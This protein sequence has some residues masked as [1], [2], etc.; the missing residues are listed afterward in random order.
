M[1]NTKSAEKR[2]R[3]NE[4]RRLHNRI[5]EGR[6][7]TAVKKARL[8]IQAGDPAA[9]DAVHA[10]YKALDKAASKGSIHDN[11]AARRKSRLAMALNKVQTQ[12]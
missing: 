9:V 11:N 6:A 10:A 12:A 4:R 2:A 7:R 5:F 3:Q 1:A 8:L